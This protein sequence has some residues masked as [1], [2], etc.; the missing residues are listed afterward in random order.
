MSG[1]YRRD[2]KSPPAGIRV[3][4]AEKRG[5]GKTFTDYNT[6]HTWKLLGKLS[7]T[8]RETGKSAAQVALRWLLQRPGVTAPI[9]A[10]RTMD[11]LEDNLGASGWSLS[12][13]QMART[14]KT[15]DKPLPYPYDLQP[16]QTQDR[17][18]GSNARF[19]RLRTDDLRMNSVGIRWSMGNWDQ[20][21][22]SLRITSSATALAIS[23][24][25]WRMAA[26]PG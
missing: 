4:M 26:I 9:I 8:A 20:S 3:E 12:A 6:E 7:E 17:A 15:S 2:M 18:G 21:P 19:Q 14:T 23:S 16:I 22:E 24:L 25:G 11:H 13:E 5:W 1:R 10:A